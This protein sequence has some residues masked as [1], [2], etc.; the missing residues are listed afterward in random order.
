M[1][2]RAL[3]V[4]HLFLWPY[5]QTNLSVRRAE[6]C[7]WCTRLFVC[8]VFCFQGDAASLFPLHTPSILSRSSCCEETGPGIYGEHKKRARLL[9]PY[10]FEIYGALDKHTELKKEV[11]NLYRSLE[12]VCCACSQRV[13][14]LVHVCAHVSCCLCT[15]PAVW[16]CVDLSA[17]VPAMPV[18]VFLCMSVCVCVCVCLCTPSPPALKHQQQITDGPPALEVFYFPAEARYVKNKHVQ[19]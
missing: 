11:F 3:F 9:S 10:S 16:E 7:G 1:H 5:F 2:K 17:C 19:H 18:C 6:M 4:I 8:L 13:Q 12:P 15:P 14:L